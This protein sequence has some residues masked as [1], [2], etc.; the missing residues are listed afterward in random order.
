MVDGF[1][2]VCCVL[3][4]RHGCRWV[5]LRARWFRRYHSGSLGSSKHEVE[6]NGSFGFIGFI[7]ARHGGNKGALCGRWFYSGLLCSFGGVLGVIGFI[8][9]RVGF[10]GFVRVRWVHPSAPWSSS[11]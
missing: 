11:G 7:R 3:R 9:G 6:V 2:R 8:R 5:H 1:I 4:E 10:V